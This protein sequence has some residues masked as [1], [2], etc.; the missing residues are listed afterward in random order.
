MY[1]M[2]KVREILFNLSLLRIG[3][4]YYPVIQKYFHL[5]GTN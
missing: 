3:G 2:V 5:H 1:C 4:W